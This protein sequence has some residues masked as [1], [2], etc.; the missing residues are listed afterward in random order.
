M[1]VLAHICDILSTEDAALIIQIILFMVSDCLIA[2]KTSILY[3]LGT[4]ILMIMQL[5]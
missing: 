1:L 5:Y 4:Y 2:F 3:I